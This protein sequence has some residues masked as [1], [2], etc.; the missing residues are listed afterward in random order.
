MKGK[1][2]DLENKIQN[3]QSRLSSFNQENENL[4]ASNADVQKIKAQAQDENKQLKQRLG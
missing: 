4:K 3:Y 2:A 1:V